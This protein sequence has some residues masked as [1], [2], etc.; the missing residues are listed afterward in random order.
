MTDT[1]QIRYGTLRDVK[2]LSS[3]NIAMAQETEDK[4]L[5]PEVAE[6]GVENLLN[7]PGKG[8]YLIAES[9][10]QI[11]GSL[12]ITKEWSDWRNGFFWWIQ[13]VYVLPEFRR[14]GIFKRL[15]QKIRSLADEEQNVC[16]LRL[17]VDRDNSP[18]I[19]TYKAMDMQKTDYLLFET[20][21]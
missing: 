10:M 5:D 11:A 12:M 21:F 14:K 17:Y 13:S 9:G 7:Q 20:E 18:A 19:K 15:Y 2:T 6:K 1:I 3:F 16:G 4:K 8:F